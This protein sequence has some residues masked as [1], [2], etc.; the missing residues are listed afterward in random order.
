MMIF[1]VL[2]IVVDVRSTSISFIKPSRALRA[3]AYIHKDIHGLMSVGLS[4]LC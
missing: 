4:C 1:F 2:I 3:W